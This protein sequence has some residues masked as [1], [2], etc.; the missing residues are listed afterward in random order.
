MLAALTYYQLQKDSPVVS[1][2]NWILKNYLHLI[3]NS[4]TV[5]LIAIFDK[6]LTSRKR[7][8]FVSMP[9]GKAEPDDHFASIQRVAK[10]V[11]ERP[12]A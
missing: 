11:S 8:I 9:F 2:V 4:N 3:E 12:T 1:F 7:T 10:E 6:V 5:D